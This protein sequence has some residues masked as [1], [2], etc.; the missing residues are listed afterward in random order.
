MPISGDVLELNGKLDAA[1]ELVNSDP[2]GDGW[3]VKIKIT[4]AAEV[5]GLMSAADYKTLINA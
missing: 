3:M 2:Y 1:P 4:N 5:A